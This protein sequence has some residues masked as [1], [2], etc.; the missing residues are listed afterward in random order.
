MER[1]QNTR[2]SF[3]ATTQKGTGLVGLEGR[4]DSASRPG[5]GNAARAQGKAQQSLKMKRF[6][7]HAFGR[8]S[9]KLVVG[10]DFASKGSQRRAGP[11]SDVPP[12]RGARSPL[13]TQKNSAA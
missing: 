8:S 7:V 11:A 1:R 3:R 13:R 5:R 2:P 9:R 10:V 4:E 12:S 6:G